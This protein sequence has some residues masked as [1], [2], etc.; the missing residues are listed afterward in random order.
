MFD[1]VDENSEYTYACKQKTKFSDHFRKPFFNNGSI[2]SLGPEQIRALVLG[3]SRTR[4][5]M[6]RQRI[7]DDLHT[8]VVGSAFGAGI[9]GDWSVFADT[10]C[11]D[12]V[13][14]ITAGYNI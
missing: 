9:V 12:H 11:D 1:G 5:S 4:V 14:W 6:I 8:P 13:A 10:L 7:D 2:F 3:S